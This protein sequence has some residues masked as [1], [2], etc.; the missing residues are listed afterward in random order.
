[1]SMMK[2]LE[3]HSLQFRLEKQG[4]SERS[5]GTLYLCFR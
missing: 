3:H 4:D 1:M 5:W 2:L